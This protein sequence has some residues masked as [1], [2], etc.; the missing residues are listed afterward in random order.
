ME[1][2]EVEGTMLA[3]GCMMGDEDVDHAFGLHRGVPLRQPR[4]GNEGP[5]LE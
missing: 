2:G 3:T 5:I 4:E 1:I